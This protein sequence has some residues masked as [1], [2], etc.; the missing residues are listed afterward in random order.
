[1]DLIK[2]IS[3]MS[4]EQIKKVALDNDF[5]GNIKTVTNHEIKQKFRNIGVDASNDEVEEFKTKVIKII[6]HKDE[7]DKT[8]SENKKLPDD[9]LS[10][11]GGGRKLIV[12][13]I[14]ESVV[15]QKKFERY[16]H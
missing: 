5:F 9:E 3:N 10:E 4:W 14:E 15:P 11:F 8:V 16:Y 1:M 13:F 12:N 6:S 2:G 7:L